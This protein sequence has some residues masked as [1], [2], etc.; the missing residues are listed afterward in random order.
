MKNKVILGWKVA[1]GILGVGTGGDKAGIG[2]WE[3]QIT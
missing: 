3:S 1:Q 2:L